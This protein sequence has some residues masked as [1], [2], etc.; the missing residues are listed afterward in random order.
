MQDPLLTW[1]WKVLKRNILMQTI[2][3]TVAAM[4]VERR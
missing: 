3:N 2:S 1:T 4:A